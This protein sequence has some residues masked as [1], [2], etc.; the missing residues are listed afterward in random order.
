MNLYLIKSGRL[1]DRLFKN[2][3]HMLKGHV[4]TQSFFF[5]QS[6]TSNEIDCSTGDIDVE[7]F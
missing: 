1:I 2:M 5:W 4:A 6:L 7:I 3:E